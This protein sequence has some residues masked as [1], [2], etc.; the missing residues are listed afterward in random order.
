MGAWAEGNFDNDT[1]LDLVAGVAKDMANES[2][3]PS[4]VEDIDL[5]MAAV[6]VRKALVEHCRA[7][8]PKIAEIEALKASVLALYDENID[9]LDPDPDYKTG[10]R[11][12]IAET[13]D[14]FLALLAG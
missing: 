11:Q 1:A 6:A 5:V 7:P 2:K 10:R 14:Q 8:K 3:L 12:V 13:F 4:D 9:D